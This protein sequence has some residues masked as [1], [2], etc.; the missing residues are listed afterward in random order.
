MLLAAPM[1]LLPIALTLQ[2]GSLLSPQ[3]VPRAPLPRC[4]AQASVLAQAEARLP[5]VSIEYCSRCNWM[6][7]SAWLSQELLTTFNG[8]LA[9][10]SLVPNHEGSGTFVCTLVTADGD[11]VTE[12]IIWDRKEEGSFPEA[13]ALK[14]KV[15]DVLDPSRDLG[16]SDASDGGDGEKKTGKTALQRI[17]S[18]LKGDRRRRNDPRT[19]SGKRE[20]RLGD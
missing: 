7:R 14:Q 16:H 6:L 11:D 8:T 9:E 10:V 2:A 18:V 13:K 20:P 17:L 15:R 12:E 1:L 3:L 5:K 4:Q 19:N